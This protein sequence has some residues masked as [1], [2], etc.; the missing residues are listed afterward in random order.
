MTVAMGEPRGLDDI[1][2]ECESE[3]FVTRNFKV[4]FMAAEG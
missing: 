1:T 4:C 3:S 2:H